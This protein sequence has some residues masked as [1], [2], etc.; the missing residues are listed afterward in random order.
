MLADSLLAKNGGKRTHLIEQDERVGVARVLFT[1]HDMDRPVYASELFAEHNVAGDAY[2][3]GRDSTF[4]E[5]RQFLDV[6][7]L[8]ERERV[9]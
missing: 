2:L 5:I 9:A 4:E 3:I 6:L 1:V 7:Q 8:H